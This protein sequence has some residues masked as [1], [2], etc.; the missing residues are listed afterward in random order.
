M[1]LLTPFKSSRNHLKRRPTDMPRHIKIGLI[2]LIGA[3]AVASGFFVDVIG[4]VQSLMKSERET[5][6]NPFKQPPQPLYNPT[7]PPVTVKIFFPP[8][9]GETLLVAEDEMIFKS[10]ELANRAK[11]ILQRVQEGPQS[12]KL[13]PS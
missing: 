1:P 6:Q 9:T 4:H 8:V 11:Q 5:E 2:I 3:L 12:D 7:D 13:L 10:S